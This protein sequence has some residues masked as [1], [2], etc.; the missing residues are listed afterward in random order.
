MAYPSSKAKAEKIVL[1][2]N[3]TK[4]LYVLQHSFHKYSFKVSGFFIVRQIRQAHICTLYSYI[5]KSGNI[6]QP[7]HR[8]ANLL[9]AHFSC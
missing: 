9:K 1:E 7:S 5:I 2:A 3:G 6:F 4:V 8:E